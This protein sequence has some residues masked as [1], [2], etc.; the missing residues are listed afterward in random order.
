L[1]NHRQP[2]VISKQR[3]PYLRV[4]PGESPQR[5]RHRRFTT[6]TDL[7][8]GRPI[9]AVHTPVLPKEVIPQF[10]GHA[11]ATGQCIDPIAIERKFPRPGLVD[12]PF[13]KGRIAGH[14]VAVT[15]PEDLERMKNLVDIRTGVLD[16][17]VALQGGPDVEP[18][19]PSS[20]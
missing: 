4:V 13:Q 9:S 6:D 14:Q 12:N 8:I 19:R 18:S 7:E 2:A 10:L 1:K 5:H 20:H 11:L 17:T 16:E 3:P 15:G